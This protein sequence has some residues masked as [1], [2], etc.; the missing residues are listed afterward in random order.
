MTG[1]EAPRRLPA[2][3]LPLTIVAVLGG[4][5]AIGALF[6]WTSDWFA[7]GAGAAAC[8]SLW[9]AAWQ[10]P[11]DTASWRW[12]GAAAGLWGVGAV[13]RAISQIV[14]PGQV[15]TLSLADL[16]HVAAIVAMAAGFVVPTRLP[17]SPRQWLRH[18]ADSYVCGVALFVLGWDTVFGRLFRM[19]DESPA[20]FLSE[21]LFP[22]LDVVL[23]CA[24]LPFVLGAARR[25]RPT[26]VIAYVAL[27]T[28]AAGDVVSTVVRLESGTS[29]LGDVLR[30]AGLLLLGAVPWIG[31]AARRGGPRGRMV[32][33]GIAPALLAGAAAMFVAGHTLTGSRPVEP[34]V[35]IV[36][37]TALL[38]LIAR[39]T[40]L[41][42]ENDR[43]K[44]EIRAGEEHFRAL[45]ESVEDLVLICDEP[46][47]VQYVNAGEQWT[48]AHA[49]PDLLGRPLTELL[50]P[51]DVAEV[52][53]ALGRC[54]QEAEQP[55]RLACRLR[56]EDGTWLPT[57]STFS[58]Y[59]PGRV[60]ITVRD[61]SEEA[62]LKRQVDHLTFHDGLT[63]LP[64][65]A[66]FEERTR[67]VLTRG[68][69]TGAVIFVDL[70]GFTAVNDS[71][72]HAAGDQVLAQAARRLR[73]AVPAT[74][75]VARWGGDEFAVLVEAA[76]D[77]QSVVDL[78]ERLLR[79]L[80]GE[81]YR[82]GERGIAL[83]AGIGVAFADDDLAS[84]TEAHSLDETGSASLIRNGDLAMTR[85]KELGGGRVEVFATQMHA[86]VVRRMELSSDLQRAL[87]AEEFEV[88]F[89]PVVD[90]ADG[91]VTGVEA[92]ARWRRDGRQ[93]PP[94]EFL[95]TAEESG[96]IVQLGA[97]V[98][99]EACA[100]VARW[101]AQGWEIGLS[102]NFTA[103]QIASPK[104]AGTVAAAL[105]ETG[106][107][108]HALT[109]EVKEEV[110]VEQ[111][112][113]DE[114]H[115]ARLAALRD[116][117]VR[118]A[119]DDFG[120]GYA[121]LAFLGQLPVDVIK[122]DPSFTAGLEEDETR[123]LL[124]RTII[125]LGSDL[126]LT[127]VAEG[128]ESA[129]QQEILREMGCHRG[130]GFHVARPMSAARVD[131][132]IRPGVVPLPGVQ[133]G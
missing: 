5:Y 15:M 88:E 92:L 117:G 30:F 129:R 93:V 51:E 34:V 49:L 63:G 127:V 106:L 130:Q 111:A 17:R 55:L 54:E 22:L 31:T 6:G 69:A 37:G 80:S 10:K 47:T 12:F 98:L 77:A 76:P 94:E 18:T 45:A 42:R 116:L 115:A 27:L 100:E 102:V 124:T 105:T 74:D 110:L 41:L 109:L 58:R 78:A 123:A 2:Q 16:F 84:T 50:H 83:T 125:R 114:Q 52:E 119:I 21:L 128:I 90:L 81:P 64:N 85:A 26:T 36:A 29:V 7:A 8:G 72:G 120:T 53:A 112:Q 14:L 28:I 107:P 25:Q 103:R 43:L 122:I 56:T 101:R 61:L 19:S 24:L 39:L 95:G 82:V 13:V 11:G 60:L 35:L 1:E 32:G 96:L 33:P 65:R 70:D 3:A 44:S 67:Q 73:A 86:A 126:G 87:A 40:D 62:A 133:A 132:E 23:I 97:W 118:L 75:T 9:Y 46:G 4:L 121:S 91:K 71:A 66:Y 131:A 108:P 38:V 113:G 68:G 79:V 57:E 48:T 20:Q 99:R 89:Q 59:A 104:I